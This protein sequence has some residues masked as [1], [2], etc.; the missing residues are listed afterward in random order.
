MDISPQSGIP[1]TVRLAFTFVTA[2]RTRQATCIG[3]LISLHSALGTFHATQKNHSK[4]KIDPAGR[5]TAI[6][7]CTNIDEAAAVRTKQV[8]WMALHS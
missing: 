4:Q 2:V 7:E 5:N 1:S 8:R 3:N 6:G